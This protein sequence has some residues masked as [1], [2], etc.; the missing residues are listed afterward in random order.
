MALLTHK[1]PQMSMRYSHLADSA[2]KRSANVMGRIVK[3]AEANGK[4]ET[5]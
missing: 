1:S 5:A 2:L 3:E 4:T